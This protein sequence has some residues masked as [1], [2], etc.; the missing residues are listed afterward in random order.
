MLVMAILQYRI[1]NAASYTYSYSRK[2][3]CCLDG[4]LMVE[5]W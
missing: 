3:S 2:S 1:G 5:W 4:E